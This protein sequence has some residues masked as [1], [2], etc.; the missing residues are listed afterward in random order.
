MPRDLFGDVSDP[1]IRL[2]SRKWYTVPVS[3]AVHTAALLVLIVVPLMAAGALPVPRGDEMFISIEPVDLPD[4]PP[5][6]R[7]EPTAERA[8]SS[9]AVPLEPPSQITPELDVDAGFE[10]D[11]PDPGLV[12]GGVGDGPGLPLDPPPPP[13]EPRPQQPVHVGGQIKR[14][15]KVHDVAPIYPPIA[16]RARIEGLVIVEATI[17]IDGRV[18]HARVLRSQAFLD[19]AALT[20]VQQ[21]IFTPT[22]LNGVAVPVIMTVTVVFQLR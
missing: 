1:S 13:P 5:V 7:R 2:G 22:R 11:A 15:E 20:A 12:G 6:I 8:E 21:W 19:D 17:G 14:P 18:Q 10:T 9:R 3:L 16:Q 4:P